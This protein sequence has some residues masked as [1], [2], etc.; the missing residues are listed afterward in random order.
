[1][2]DE[3]ASARDPAAAD[4][5]YGKGGRDMDASVASGRS[6]GED[7]M[8]SMRDDVGQGAP[9]ENEKLVTSIVVFLIFCF[10]IP[11]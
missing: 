9:A 3:E 10:S 8:P 1:M 6:W 4:R 2:V 11:K 5:S 7:S